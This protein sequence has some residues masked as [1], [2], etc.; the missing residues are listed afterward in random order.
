MGYC[1]AMMPL[2]EA[3]SAADRILARERARHRGASGRQHLLLWP[4]WFSAAPDGLDADGKKRVFESCFAQAGQAISPAGV[5]YLGAIVAFQA[6]F[7]PHP[8]VLLTT[9][10]VG[11]IVLLA[12]VKPTRRALHRRLL[13]LHVLR[14]TRY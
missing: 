8:A 3:A 6:G 4:T 11:T 12:C 5:L 1:S 9:A 14:S 10:A 7:W 2:T 13:R